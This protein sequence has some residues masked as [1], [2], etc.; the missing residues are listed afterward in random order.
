MGGFPFFVA[1]ADF[2]G[3]GSA[4]VAVTNASDSTVSVLLGK[5]DGTFTQ[6]AGSPIPGFNYN[7]AQ[8]VAADFNGDGFPDLA[9]AD[10]TPVSGKIPPKDDQMSNVVVMLGKGD[11]TFTPA[12]GSPITVGLY[13]TM[14]VAAD[15]NQ[16]GKTDLAVGNSGDNTDLP[17]QTL[18]LLLG[19][20]KGGF[21]PAGP[22][23]QLGNSPNDMVAADFNGDGTTAI[24]RFPTW[25]DLTTTSPSC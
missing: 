3:D 9:V 10:F 4:D 23:T 21:A 18:T 7:P 12:A 19:D 6:A 24:W 20:G 8:V 2:N 1:V 25:A 15:F 14:L 13:A 16:D 5:G 11:G 17:T 22:P